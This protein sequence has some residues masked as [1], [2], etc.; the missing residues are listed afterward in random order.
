MF[1]KV[2]GTARHDSLKLFLGKAVL[3]AG[4]ARRLAILVSHRMR[5]IVKDKSRCCSIFLAEFFKDDY[6]LSLR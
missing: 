1:S 3:E 6:R 5:E 4:E 2:Q